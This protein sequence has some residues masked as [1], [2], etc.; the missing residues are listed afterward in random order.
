MHRQYHKWY[1]RSLSRDM[2]LLQ[3]G[4]SGPPMLVFPSSMGSFYEYEDRGMVDAVAT[5][6]EGG[7]LQLFC[8]SS[9]DTESWYNRHVHP[10]E[11][12]RRHLQYEDYVLNDVVP[13][14][15]HVNRHPTI[16]LT[17]CSFGA[18]HA[19]TFAL[20]RP[21]D[22]TWCVTM[23]GSYDI[24]PFLDGYFDEDCY[25]LNP[26]SFLPGLEDAYYLDQYRRNKWVLVTGEH[27]ICRGTNEAFSALLH[28]KAIAHSLH[29][30]GHGAKHDWADWVP[31]ASAY[32]P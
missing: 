20:R 8:L 3:F 1:S 24:A 4:H 16:G 29:V 31:M 9:V 6:L 19:M 15:H 13:L 21:Y 12:V 32:L 27:D 22:F 7:G 30:W 25:F 28:S 14:V 26:S 17:G 10:R 11:R 23:S 5:K 2:E 18:Y